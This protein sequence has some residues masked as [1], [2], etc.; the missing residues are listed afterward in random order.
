MSGTKEK[1]PIVQNQSQPTT[2]KAPVYRQLNSKFLRVNSRGL[3][4]ETKRLKDKRKAVLEELSNLRNESMSA[5]PL[6]PDPIRQKSLYD[7]FLEESVL[8]ANDFIEERKWKI[9]VAYILVHEAQAFYYEHIYKKE[10][11]ADEQGMEVEDPSSRLIDHHKKIGHF[12]SSMVNEFWTNVK[13]AQNEVLHSKKSSTESKT[14]EEP[15]IQYV[16]GV[17]ADDASSSDLTTSYMNKPSSLDSYLDYCYHHHLTSVIS[18]SFTNPAWEHTFYSIF[19][20]IRFFQHH[21][22]I[23]F[24]PEEYLIV[25]N[26]F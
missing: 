17:N 13:E 24:I 9:Q 19:K 10:Q 3:N 18:C 22:C 20:Q 25:F 7:Y 5:F 2:H 12:L 23:L 6:T 16:L 26:L 1:I 15:L 14:I 21:E 4:K 8:V 11:S